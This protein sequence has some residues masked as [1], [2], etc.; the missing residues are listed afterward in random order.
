MKC[1]VIL[2]TNVRLKLMSLPSIFSG[3][4]LKDSKFNMEVKFSE[5]WFVT[6]VIA[7]S[8]TTT[9]NQDPLMTST[10]EPKTDSPSKDTNPALT[11]D[12]TTVKSLS[13]TTYTD[14]TRSN[15]NVSQRLNLSTVAQISNRIVTP[16]LN[17]SERSEISRLEITLT[18]A[19][20]G[21]PRKGQSFTKATRDTAT[22]TIA[23]HLS[24]SLENTTFLPQKQMTHSKIEHRV[25]TNMITTEIVMTEDY[26]STMLNTTNPV[27]AMFI[28]DTICEYACSV[29]VATTR[30]ETFH[31]SSTDTMYSYPSTMSYFTGITA[32]PNLVFN[33]TGN[34]TDPTLNSQY[35]NVYDPE[36]CKI[37]QS[38]EQKKKPTEKTLYYRRVTERIWRNCPPVLF[39]IGTIGNVLS[40][41]VMMRRSLRTSITSFF[42]VTL[43]VVDTFMLWNGLMRQFLRYAHGIFVRSHSLAAC[44]LHIF[45]TYWGGQF[46]AW[47]LVCMTMERF[48]AIFSPHKSKQYVSKLSCGI[49]VGV[50]GVLLAGLN[51]HFFKT[52]LLVFFG[53]YYCATDAQYYDFMQKIWTWIDFAF[54]SFI[55][56]GI[57]VIANAGIIIRIAHSNY[58]RK[59]NMKQ[60]SGGVKMTSMTAILLTVSLIFLLTTAPISIYLLIQENVKRSSTEEEDAL[61]SLWW[62]IVVNVNYINHSCNFFL[63]CISGPR[64]RRELRGMFGLHRQVYPASVTQTTEHS[65]KTQGVTLP[66]TASSNVWHQCVWH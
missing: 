59:H 38:Q 11:D 4:I 22:L 60:S 10:G 2:N 50:I 39:F 37:C 55:P 42:L 35:Q 30:N 49:V 43:A 65:V 32:V 61:N 27:T 29:I 46:A 19:D 28:N 13:I 20:E 1:T 66:H 5:F 47:I 31:N 36:V 64:F 23:T 53:R 21:L 12:T 41:V 44:R 18:T 51:A 6:T 26:N 15:E 7:L 62:A 56:F 16:S 24:P 48:F 58:V 14:I 25:D 57:L 9:T 3:L 8:V 52:H 33:S 17:E 63:Y 45:L 34:Y 40:G 54:F